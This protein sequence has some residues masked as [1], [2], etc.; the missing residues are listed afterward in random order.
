MVLKNKK[1]TLLEEKS[2]Y[3]NVMAP[4]LVFLSLFTDAGLRSLM[5]KAAKAQQGRTE[6]NEFN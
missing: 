5:L 1:N 2:Q 3:I 6:P 4:F